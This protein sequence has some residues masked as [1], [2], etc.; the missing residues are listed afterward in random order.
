MAAILGL[1]PLASLF[2]SW[3]VYYGRAGLADVKS[4]EG[5]EW[6]EFLRPNLPW[7]LMMWAK[8]FVWPVVLIVWLA[9]DRPASPWR[10]V[11]SVDG[12]PAR[13]IV[14][15]SAENQRRVSS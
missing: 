13:A 10:A 4:R 7:F 6:R 3:F 14:R 1:L 5:V 15:I 8:C 9:Q 11:T 2:V 12:R